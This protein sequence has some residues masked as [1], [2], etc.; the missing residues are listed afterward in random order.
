MEIKTVQSVNAMED[1]FRNGY[2]VVRN[3]SILCELGREMKWEGDG[4]IYVYVNVR[5]RATYSNSKH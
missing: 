1:A 3:G 2:V 4:T 5:Y